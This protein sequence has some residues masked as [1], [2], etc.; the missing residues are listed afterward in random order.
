VHFLM[1]VD[2]PAAMQQA[3]DRNVDA[4]RSEMREARIRY[5]TANAEPGQ[6]EIRFQDAAERDRAHDLLATQL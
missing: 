3:L 5:V 4:M 6:I 1:E 2:M